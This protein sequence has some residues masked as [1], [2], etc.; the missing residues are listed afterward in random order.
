MAIKNY[1]AWSPVLKNTIEL[2][3]IHNLNWLEKKYV[4]LLTM[5]S[6]AYKNK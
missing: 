1:L 4:F 5:Q 6:I 3:F 2:Q